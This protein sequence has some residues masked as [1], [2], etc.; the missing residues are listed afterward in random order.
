VTQASL[1]DWAFA[2]VPIALLLLLVLWGRFSIT[3][4]GLVVIL[5]AG[6]IGCVV[7][8]AGAAT[9]GVA[10]G[11][12]VSTGIWILAVIWP[13]LFLFRAAS[14]MGL[15][16]IGAQLGLLLP[17]PV[18]NILVMAWIVPSFIQGVA[19]FGVPVAVAAPLLMQMGVGPVRAVALPL[20]GSQ[21][22]VGFGSMGS[23]F[24]MGSLATQLQP[25]E[26]HAYAITASLLSASN[27][28]LGG[29]LVCLM[30]G[31]WR[32]LKEGFWFL[33]LVA[34]GM[35]IVQAFAVRAEPSIGAL[36]AGAVGL[37]IVALLA[38]RQ[39]RA[40]A[41]KSSRRRRRSLMRTNAPTSHGSA[42]LTHGLTDTAPEDVTDT[43]DAPRTRRAA[44]VALPYLL[45]TA[46]VL[47][48][49]LNPATRSWVKAHWLL[50][51]DFPSTTSGHGHVNAAAPDYS[52]IPLLGH[53]GTYV[54]LATA[55]S[56][57]VWR[58]GGWWP[59][60]R[61]R[62]MLSSW[63]GQ[64]RRSSPAVVLLAIVATIMTDSGMISTAASGVAEATGAHYPLIAA[65]IGMIGAFTTGSS[66][67]S[68]ALF[69]PMQ[70]EIAHRVGFPESSALALQ[71]AGSNVGN[72]I[73][74]MSALVGTSAIGRKD[75]TSQVVRIAFLPAL[76]LGAALVAGA[77]LLMVL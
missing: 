19:G 27:L 5:T 56:L 6:F 74:P 16:Q 75:L 29:V 26:T 4:N 21:W 20:V 53:P 71:L 67:S 32:S 40:A 31:G 51:Y 38:M 30:Y 42:A 73:S 24:Y 17:R 35:A 22:S 62:P 44:I 7:F 47:A 11:K 52:A 46:S 58:L 18:E 61:L 8:G 10:V 68:Q 34:P 59:R 57:I 45:L 1:V 14:E 77:A 41:Q 3:V 43:A 54:M 13:A 15:L 60:R 65:A 49:F 25:Q 9:L 23:S 64:A 37:L 28:V 66:T 39:R 50:G 76:L 69:A 36:C 70:Y 33:L 48:V 55:V 72:S 12:G 2:V 63:W